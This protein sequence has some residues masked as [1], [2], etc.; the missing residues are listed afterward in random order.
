[1]NAVQS[2]F[3]TDPT[4]EPE[5]WYALG[6][7]QAAIL[8]LFTTGGSWAA[9]AM[10]WRGFLA[11]NLPLLGSAVWS[12]MRKPAYRPAPTAL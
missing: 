3:G 4:V 5:P 2:R 6:A 11:V 1:M 8:S 10:D 12:A 9:A 7:V